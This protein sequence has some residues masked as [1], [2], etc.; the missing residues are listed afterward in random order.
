ML[1]TECAVLILIKEEVLSNK[2]LTNHN[3]RFETVISNLFQL[4][5]HTHTHTHIYIYIIYAHKHAYAHT[6]ARTHTRTHTISEWQFFLFMDVFSSARLC[7]FNFKYLNFVSTKTEW[8]L[9]VHAYIYIFYTRVQILINR[10]DY[11]WVSSVRT[12]EFCKRC[13]GLPVLIVCMVS[14][15]VKQHW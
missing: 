6:S 10:L 8:S 2:K 5:T 4:F 7:A 1:G 9:V 11:P 15:D 14:V 12:Q 3:S 13:P